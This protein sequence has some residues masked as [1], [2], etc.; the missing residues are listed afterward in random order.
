MNKKTFSYQIILRNIHN[1]SYVGRTGNGN[2]G[3]RY[4]CWYGHL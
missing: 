2:G 1:T 4:Q 3:L